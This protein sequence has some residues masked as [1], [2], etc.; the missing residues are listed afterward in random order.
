MDIFVIGANFKTASVE[1]REKI[2]VSEETLKQLKNKEEIK[3]LVFLSTCN[4]VEFYG[5]AGNVEEAYQVI[6]NTISSVS[7]LSKSLLSKKLY[8]YRGG[9]A[10]KHI[11]KVASSIDSMVIG[12]PQ[13]VKQFKEAFDKGKKLG[14][15]G[16]IL[17]RLGDK[18]IQV[19]KK[20]RTSTGIS[21]KAV[22]I[23]YV[24]VQLAKKIF[25]DLKDKT[26]LLI[27]AG[28]M[29]E[30]ALRNLVS[31]K[32]QSIFIAN[33]TLEKA[34]Q[35]AEEFGGG[36][37]P[38]ESLYDFLVKAD[39]II[40]S[41]GAKKPI[42]KKENFRNIG[43]L[44]KGKPIFII[45]ISVPR[46]VEEDVNSI[47][48]IYLYNVDDLK[49]IADKNLEDRKIAAKSAELLIEKD[50]YTFIRWL[51]QQ[52]ASPL[53][54]KLKDFSDEI[55]EYQL[56]KLFKQMPYLNE[57]ERE[58]IELMARAIV[59]KLLHRPI[60][61]LKEKVSQE[62]NLDFIKEF[63]DIFLKPK[64]DNLNRFINLKEK[65]KIKENK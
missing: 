37:I 59:K 22:S 19:S 31:Q 60:I 2:T 3:E 27:G 21:K 11:F 49:E 10:V 32:V 24:A 62:D 5:V 17:T 55:I 33:R 56:D 47:E 58:N 29:G 41:T 15:V 4:R 65:K 40:V 35:L 53:I 13:I 52:K 46:N 8:F 64:G 30:L 16:Y 39:I 18:A 36:V 42:L 48:N 45:D 7:G 43:S 1:V 44:R 23:S 9:E 25:G 12:E 61:H 26:V 38:F 20:I 54:S 14:T 50:V 6:L 57:K 63:E 51:K 34:V 28:E